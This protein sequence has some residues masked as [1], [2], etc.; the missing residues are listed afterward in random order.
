[1]A[2][3]AN[4]GDMSPEQFDRVHHTSQSGIEVV[5]NFHCE[6]YH[7]YPVALKNL[8]GWVEKD[9]DQWKRTYPARDTYVKNC[10]CTESVVTFADRNAMASSPSLSDEADA[11]DNIRKLEE[12]QERPEPGTGGALIR[13]SYRPLITAWQPSGLDLAGDR[14]EIPTEVFDYLDPTFRPAVVQVPW[15]GGLFAKVKF[16]LR[17]ATVAVP[18]ELSQP[19]GVSVTDVSI[20]RI[21][22]PLDD[23]TLL[24]TAQAANSVNGEE[25]PHGANEAKNGLPT[26]QPRTLKF[27]GTDLVNRID[28]EGQRW[29]ELIHN[30]KWIQHISSRLFDGDGNQKTGWVTWNH[31]FMR[32]PQKE[33]GWYEIYLGTSFKIFGIEFGQLI[34]GLEATEGRLHNETNFDELFKLNR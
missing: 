19:M 8:H 11:E 26:F 21:L 15:P 7:T 33:A 12:T 18:D 13:A 22:V 4:D 3:N 27:V 25:W 1:M 16:P 34:P 23:E 20:R 17:T 2:V 24:P 5:R 29:V 28:S 32:P 30:F 10:F 6:P 31:V 14:D 9:G